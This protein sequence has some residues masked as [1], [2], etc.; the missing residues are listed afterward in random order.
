[1]PIP[2]IPAGHIRVLVER[3]RNQLLVFAAE[4]VLGG[5][6]PTSYMKD[7]KNQFHLSFDIDTSYGAVPI[8]AGDRSDKIHIDDLTPQSSQKFLVRG[9]VRAT[10]GAGVQERLDGGLVHSDP[11]VSGLLTCGNSRAVG[12]TTDVQNNL[13]TQ[14]LAANGFDGSRVAIAVVDT[15]IYLDRLTQP[16][17]SPQPGPVPPFDMASSIS[18]PNIAIPP[19]SHRLGHG[20]MCAYDALIAAPKATLIDIAMLIARAPGDHSVPGT[21]SAAIWAYAHLAKLWLTWTAM[22]N[23]RPYDALV[24]NNSWGIYHPSLDPFPQ[25]SPSRYIDNPDHVFSTSFTRP[26][27][28]AG[29]DILFASNNCGPDCASATCLSK[30]DGMIMGANAYKEVL[31][32]GGCDI[33]FD[34]VGYSS[35]G[36]SINGMYANKPDIT[37]YTHFLGSKTARIWAPDT[38]VSA[39]CAVTAG[40]VAALRSKVLP[41]ATPPTALFDAVRTTAQRGNGG[42]PAGIWNKDYG[43]GIIDPVA[44][45]R[46]LGQRIP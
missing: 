43:F 36:P 1:M 11:A 4:A 32:I 5:N 35:E 30:Y 41:T 31:T 12:G 17:G 23:L 15:G 40:C 10:N 42:G 29:V 8:G 28:L 24:V 46:S 27:A 3:P 16:L 14:K 6:D 7:Y 44:A 18:P 39:A 34:R 37:S 21:V 33:N 38:G 19:F 13:R 45:G 22:G 9:F 2:H 25:G 20:T 26:L